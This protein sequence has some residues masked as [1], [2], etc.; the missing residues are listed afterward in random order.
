MDVGEWSELT[1]CY[2]REHEWKMV[3]GRCQCRI[4]EAWLD[5]W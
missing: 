3:N 4:E 5:V 2:G 1:N